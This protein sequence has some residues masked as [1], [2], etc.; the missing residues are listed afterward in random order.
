MELSKDN[1]III[2]GLIVLVIGTPLVIKSIIKNIKLI[3]K[4]N[5]KLY[6]WDIL[7]TILSRLHYLLS[8][9]V[10][11]IKYW[12]DRYIYNYEFDNYFFIVIVPSFSLFLM[13]IES[14]ICRLKEKLDNEYISE[15]G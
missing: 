3:K 10:I 5:K 2:V 11:L 1:I 6:G 8:I 15:E 13:M 12:T 7:I 14:I 4:S 9:L